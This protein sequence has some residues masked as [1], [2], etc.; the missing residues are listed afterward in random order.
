MG[1]R[2]LSYNDDG[3]VDQIQEVSGFSQALNN[4]T[5]LP[6]NFH[7]PTR[8]YF[9]VADGATGAVAEWIAPFDCKVVFASGY[10]VAAGAGGNTIEL[11]TT[12]PLAIA[13]IVTWDGTVGDEAPTPSAIDD[14]IVSVAKGA[15]LTLNRTKA[16]GSVAANVFFDVIPA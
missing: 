8:Q 12:A 4:A 16:G 3:S 6:T 10:K 14:A 9:E 1:K 15:T 7:V 11:K 2:I 5:T 13:A